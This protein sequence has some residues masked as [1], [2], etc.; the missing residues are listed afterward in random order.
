MCRN[1]ARK[2]SSPTTFVTIM[3][4][5]PIA[6]PSKNVCTSIPTNAE[7]AD[8]RIHDFIVMGFFAE[9]QMR[10]KRVLEHMNDDVSQKHEHRR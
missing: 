7:N 6:T 5:A 9:M 3:N 1:T 4:P 8:D 10:S 2:I